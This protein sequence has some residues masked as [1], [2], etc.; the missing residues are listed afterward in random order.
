MKKFTLLASI[1]LMLISQIGFS[2]QEG[3]HQINP[4]ERE[5]KN[6]LSL[7]SQNDGKIQIEFNLH[8]YDLL[9][10]DSE[11]AFVVKANNTSDF[12]RKG[13]PHLPIYAKSVI[14]PHNKDYTINL[15]DSKFIEIRNINV[16]PSKGE[17]TRDVNPKNIPYVYGEEYKQNSF[18]PANIASIDKAY[19]L[20]NKRGQ[21]I[22]INPIQYN[23][24]SKVLRIYTSISLELEVSKTKASYNLLPNTKSTKADSKF[25]E[26]YKSHFLNFSEDKT[27]YTPLND[28]IGNMLIISHANFMDEMQDYVNWKRQRGI[29]VEMVDVASIGNAQAIKTY[30][31]NY[32]NNN[33]GLTYLLLVGDNAQVPSS[34]TSAGPS[35][36]NYGYIAGS[37]HYI[38]LFV[39]RFSGETGAQ[40]ST[41]VS[42]TIHYERDLNTQ[43]TW[44]TKGVGIASNEGSNPS[45]AEHMNTI[46]GKLQTYGYN[47]TRC[48]Q[49]GGSAQQL[50]NLLNNGTGLI[51]YVGHGSDYGFASMTYMVSDVNALTN[52]NKLPFIFDVACVNGNFTSKTC[53][54]EAWMRAT[55]NNQPTGAIAVCASTIN[56]SWVPPMIAQNEMNDILVESYANNIKRSYTGIV[57]NGMF[58]MN[59]VHGTDGD[60]MSDTWTI[61]G[62]PALQVR[63]KTPEAIAAQHNLEIPQNGTS[64]AVN[65]IGNEAFVC[66]SKQGTIVATKKSSNGSATLTFSQ[67]NNGDKLTLTVTGYNKIPYIKEITVGEIS[68]ELISNFTANKTNIEENEAIQFTDASNGNPTSWLWQF[69]GGTPASSTE[70][71]PTVS[72]SQKGEFNVS[73]KVIKAGEENTK[74]ETDMITVED[75]IIIPY[76]TPTSSSYNNYEYISR[77]K[78]S[79]IDNSSAATGY[80]DFT[81]ME[82]NIIK[83]NTYPLEVTVTKYYSADEVSAWFDWNKDGDF[84]DANETYV[85]SKTSS[86]V[87]SKNINIPTDALLGKTRMRVRV[88][89][90]STPEPCGNSSYGESEDYSVN[91]NSSRELAERSMEVVKKLIVYPNPVTDICYVSLTGSDSPLTNIS[92]VD[93]QGKQVV[94]TVL[95]ES[96]LNL[97]DLKPGLYFITL[98]DNNKKYTKKIIIK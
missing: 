15:V 5:V 7:K 78:F 72:Y 3:H 46:E 63:T 87:C 22:K 28:D 93:I 56:Q 54:A 24:I 20:R 71:N 96:K 34:S 62:D 39:G 67:Q 55:N 25:N 26:I 8:S 74:T 2:Q 27:K 17:L 98:T 66:L 51:N 45:D 73:L 18:Y 40:I 30:V 23:P 81:S 41:Q 42:R 61:F 44:L 86:G 95:T 91:I 60:K 85:L 29:P 50:T 16:L 53:F 6:D 90:N 76:C 52:T 19:I 88:T 32:Y 21:S 1:A 10:I 31:A 70:Q 97:S 58:K 48:Y 69:E 82:A 89:Y 83:G 14:T 11:N 75:I 12:I 84:A 49:D 47:I 35:D 79:N 92:I 38:D 4:Q 68:N 64:F 94:R 77:V 57:M 33:N 80:S 9:K 59:D 65:N 36:N 43:D 37:D 13:A